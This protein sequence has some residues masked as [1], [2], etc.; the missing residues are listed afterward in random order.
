MR[1]RSVTVASVLALLAVAP[2]AAASTPAD[3]AHL[4]LAHGGTSNPLQPVVQAAVACPAGERAIGGGALTDSGDAAQSIAADGPLDE[5]GMTANTGDGDV[6]RYWYT[7]VAN[8][9]GAPESYTLYAVCSASSD[10]TLAAKA[11]TV[12]GFVDNPGGG[13]GGTPG[14]SGNLAQC[15]AGARAIGGG[16]GSPEEPSRYRRAIF[17]QP[18]EAGA[19][20][21][22][23]TT[24]SVAAGW[25]FYGENYAS[26]E[27]A[28]FKVFAVCSPTSRATVAASS[29]AASST[30]QS[31][32]VCPGNA[33]ATGG[34]F[35]ATTNT[36]YAGWI[37]TAPATDAGAPVTSAGGVPRGWFGRVN[38]TDVPATYRVYSLCEPGPAPAGQ[39]AAAIRRCKRKK[40]R[41]KHAQSARKKCH[42]KR[43]RHR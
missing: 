38:A 29:F 1:T 22:G 12:P 34:G 21:T 3:D 30:A 6:P 41:R 40:H 39:P 4:V 15:P 2:S 31:A 42:H 25:Y 37:S 33:R 16:F 14:R 20:L 43:R 27:T 13:A 35:G 7:A 24:G 17:D 10:A 36:A 9:F 11:V 5:T 18:L 23:T 28:H 8:S 32:A 26:E 19:N